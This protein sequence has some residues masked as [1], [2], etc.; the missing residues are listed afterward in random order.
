MIYGR[1]ED[2]LEFYF[3]RVLSVLSL[4]DLYDLLLVITDRLKLAQ[5]SHVILHE[6]IC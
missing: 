2:R 1:T 5:F 6:N 4:V 3:S